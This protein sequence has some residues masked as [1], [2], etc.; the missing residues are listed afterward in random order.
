MRIL[1]ITNLY[2][3]QELGGYGR[4]IAGYGEDLARRGYDLRILA[5]D[6]LALQ[7][8]PDRNPALHRDLRLYG[9]WT[10][11]GISL[12]PE[13]RERDDIV[14]A[15]VAATRHALA[16]FQPDVVL[17][18]NPDFISWRCIDAVIAAGVPVLHHIGNND[19]GFDPAD[20][21]AGPLYQPAVPSAFLRE[22]FLAAGY[23]FAGASVIWPGADV[24]A[25]D[26]GPPQPRPPGPL[27]LVY[28]SLMLPYK[29]PQV[30]MGALAVLKA[31]NVAID[32]VF[33]GDS[34]DPG[35]V[36]GM[37][38]FVTKQGLGGR[39]RFVGYL[40]PDRL[41][42]LYH[43]RDVLVFPSIFDEPWGISQAEAMAA[44]LCVVSSD[45][46]GI[47]EVIENGVTGFTFPREDAMSL[48][49]L[50]TSLS[51]DPERL[52]R[53]ASAGRVQAL[54]NY[55]IPACVDKLEQE[56]HALVARS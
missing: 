7:K 23:P 49:R 52:N 50:L 56:L 26:A 45:V 29:G 30:L 11:G 36:A 31:T 53:V 27:R 35:F 18:G 43:E 17:F 25:F 3:P 32:C 44:G 22:K 21:P 20:T 2:P 33:A 15:N 14:A 4:Y 39:I 40:E 48:S 24:A 54:K 37:N 38:A 6:M 8:A 13:G 42:D 47:P 51:R 28:A 12:L 10:D 1:I 46:G 41:R 55:A 9:N 16:D 34:T 19:P 5:G